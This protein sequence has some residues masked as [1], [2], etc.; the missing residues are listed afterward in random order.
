MSISYS[1]Y[2]SLIWS[3]T[4]LYLVPFLP[5]LV[6]ILLNL[7]PIHLLSVLYLTPILPLVPIPPIPPPQ[8]GLN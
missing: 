4:L 3:F 2:L 7:V 6:P 1:P 8:S 5:Y